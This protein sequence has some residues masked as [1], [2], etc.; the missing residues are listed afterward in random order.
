VYDVNVFTKTAPDVWTKTLVTTKSNQTYTQNFLPDFYLQLFVNNIADSVEIFHT[1]R[2]KY[3]LDNT[4]ALKAATYSGI[5]EVYGG[6]FDTG[7]SQYFG[8]VK[9]TGSMVSVSKLPFTP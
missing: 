6:S 8:S 4:G 1:P 7:T 2:F 3:V 5:G 9:I